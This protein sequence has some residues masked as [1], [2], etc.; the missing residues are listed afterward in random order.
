M[1]V[2]KDD[3]IVKYSDSQEVKDLVFAR[4]IK[5]YFEHEA[6]SGE[7]IMQSDSPIIDAPPCLSDIAD[8]II[9]F[10]VEWL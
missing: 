9:K 6:F 4:L 8:E 5:Y 2:V 3:F 1:K 7:Q 10:N